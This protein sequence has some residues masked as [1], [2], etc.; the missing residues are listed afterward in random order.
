MEVQTLLKL[1]KQE[2]HT[3]LVAVVEQGPIIVLTAL[4]NLG[5]L[6]R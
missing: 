1:Q 6:A 4:E 5:S 3:V 2:V